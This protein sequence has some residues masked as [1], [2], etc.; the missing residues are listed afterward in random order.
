[1]NITEC[2]WHE[3]TQKGWECPR[4]GKIWAPWISSCDCT[5]GTTTITW[6]GMS[7]TTGAPSNVFDKNYRN[8]CTSVDS[9]WNK[10]FHYTI[11]QINEIEDQLNKLKETK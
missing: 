4:C 8:D 7:G 10:N 9:P 2:T 5:K 11:E 1:M 3:P 6:S